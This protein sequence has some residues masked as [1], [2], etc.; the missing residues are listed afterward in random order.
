M[1]IDIVLVV[2]II[3]CIAALS[4][5]VYTLRKNSG[6]IPARPAD[7]DPAGS[8]ASSTESSA[9]GSPASSAAGSAAGPPVDS[10]ADLTAEAGAQQLDDAGRRAEQVRAR[11]ETEAAAIVLR[12][13][14]PTMTCMMFRR[15]SGLPPS[16]LVIPPVIRAVIWSTAEGLAAVGTAFGAPF[17]ARAWVEDLA[18][19]SGAPPVPA[20]RLSRAERR[21]WE[22]LVKRLR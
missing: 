2:A 12:A 11:A 22:S 9:A 8:T 20:V 7:G 3:G 5:L 15:K 19:Q 14:R 18:G 4:A 6:K 16:P 10:A 21:Q 1:G 17:P 13:G